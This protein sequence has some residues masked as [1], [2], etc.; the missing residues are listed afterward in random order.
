MTFVDV[1]LDM[2]SLRYEENHKTISERGQ[3][4]SSATASRETPIALSSG[5][6][7]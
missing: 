6:G 5:F 1:N 2:Q 7:F 4:Q 3:E